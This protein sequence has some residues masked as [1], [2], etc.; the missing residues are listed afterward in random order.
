VTRY[1]I[2]GSRSTVWIE[3]RSSVHP[4]HSRAQGLTGW[5]DLAVTDAGVLDLELP[6]SAHVEFPVSNLRSSN[7]LEERELRRRIDARRH[8]TIDG[9]LTGIERLGPGRYRIGGDVTF[10]GQRRP[11]TDEMSVGFTDDGELVFEGESTFDVRDFGLDPPKILV[12][13][14]EPLVRVRVE[15]V[16]AGE[17]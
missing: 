12:L 11:H 9:D 15:I 16:A 4:I 17:R 10:M 14:V 6:V 7:P 8:P 5:I 3:A 13:K 1:S 2:D